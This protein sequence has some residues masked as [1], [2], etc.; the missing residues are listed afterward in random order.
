MEYMQALKA[1]GK[2]ELDHSALVNYY[3]KICCAEVKRK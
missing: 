1:E 2:S 3:E